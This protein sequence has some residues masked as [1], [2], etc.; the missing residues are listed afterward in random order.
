M[1]SMQR[2]PVTGSSGGAAGAGSRH[3][4]RA[5]ICV[6]LIPVAFIA[7]MLIGE[8]LLALQGFES[9]PEGFPPLVAV[10]VA[11]IPAG[12]VM[13][14]P[15]IAAVVFGFRARRRGAGGLVPAVVG[16]I[17]IAYAILANTVPLL[18]TR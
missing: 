3:L 6:A 2:R 9:G 17:A 4:Q 5:W 11:A 18:L 10:L 15:A 16:I 12:L 1:T 14:A 7:A 13:V 8:G